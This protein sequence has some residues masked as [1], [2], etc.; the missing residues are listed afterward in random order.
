MSRTKFAFPKDR[1]QDLFWRLI[2]EE[3]ASNIVRKN[4]QISDNFFRSP[5]YHSNTQMSNENPLNELLFEQLCY[6]VTNSKVVVKAMKKSTN[7][8]LKLR[9]NEAKEFFGAILL[10]QDFHFHDYKSHFDPDPKIVSSIIPNIMPLDRFDFIKNNL[11]LSNGLLDENFLAN[12]NGFL[13]LFERKPYQPQ[14]YLIIKIKRLRYQKLKLVLLYDE[15]GYFLKGRVFEENQQNDFKIFPKLLLNFFEFLFNKNHTIIVPEELL[16]LKLVQSL[17]KR[18]INCLSYFEK[19]YN[20]YKLPNILPIL[21]KEEFLI[22][23]TVCKNEKN[24]SLFLRKN[25]SSNQTI[26]YL[27]IGSFQFYQ[28]FENKGFFE[29]AIEKINKIT[30][31]LKKQWRI[32]IWKEFDHENLNWTFELIMFALETIIN[33]SYLDLGCKFEDFNKFKE[34]T[35]KFLFKNKTGIFKANKTITKHSFDK[36]F[37]HYPATME[38]CKKCVVCRK[39]S[40]KKRKSLYKCKKCSIDLGKDIPLCVQNCMMIYHQNPEKYNARKKK[41]INLEKII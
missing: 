24:E 10:M 13:S 17:Q 32:S 22:N 36:T 4:S 2:T 33:N 25:N 31:S 19:T 23:P 8:P 7:K 28:E 11:S 34:K 1:K 40:V 21:E 37:S 39:D 3:A 38:R 20:A 15:K 18:K 27:Y 12:F 41:T 35:V 6:N 29:E 26:E 5:N 9:K 14:E 16:S 30:N